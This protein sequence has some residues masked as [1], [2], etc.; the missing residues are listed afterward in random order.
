[1]INNDATNNF[2]SKKLIKTLNLS[3][4]FK[5]TLYELIVINKNKLKK[6]EQIKK[7]TKFL[8]MIIQHHHE[9]IFF[10]IVNMI[11]HNFVLKLF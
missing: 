5:K 6:N 11:N 4:Q 8:L 2:I 9:K 1:M 10:D 7:K 3:T